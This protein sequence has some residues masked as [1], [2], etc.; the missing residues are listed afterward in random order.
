MAQMPLEGAVKAFNK[1]PPRMRRSRKAIYQKARLLL[2]KKEKS[3]PDHVSRTA[4]A[5][6][7]GVTNSL[8][9]EWEEQKGLKR[10]K[11]CST[12]ADVFYRKTDLRAFFLAH[13][14]SLGRKDVPKYSP[15]L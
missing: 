12:R 8:L 2:A 3:S 11:S 4:I 5:S 13:P 9:Y 14:D 10:D 6:G 7:L 15:L 1:K